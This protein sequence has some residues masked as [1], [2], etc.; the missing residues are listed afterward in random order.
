MFHEAIRKILIAGRPIRPWTGLFVLALLLPSAR[1][2]AQSGD[3]DILSSAVPPNVMILFDNSGSMNH[4]LWD[5]DFDPEVRY[6]AFCSFGLAPMISNSSCPGHGNPS[7]ECPDNEVRGL[8]ISG[9]S[10]QNE[11]RCS[12]TRTLYHD[13][14]TPQTTWYSRN[15]L[16]WLYGVSTTA[17]R[18]NEPQQSRL[19]V[20]KSATTTVVTSLTSGATELIRFGLMEFK[21]TNLSYS[22]DPDGGQVIVPIGVG[23]S[24]FV[25]AAISATEGD[26]WTPMGE[27]LVDVGRYFAGSNPLGTLPTSPMPSPI[28][29]SCRKNFALIVTD[30]EPTQDT[31]GHYSGAFETTI[32]NWDSDANEC[33]ALAP[34]TCIDAPGT[35]RDDGL[36]YKTS[37]K[38]T[39][40]L[41]DVAGYLYDT[42]LDPTLTGTQNLVTYTI[43]FLLDLPLLQ[44]AATN[45]GGSYYV[46]EPDDLTSLSTNLS[47]ALQSI[48]DRLG[49]FSSASVPTSRTAFGDSVY[50]AYFV[51]SQGASFW[52]GHLE[53]YELAANGDL[54]DAD[55]QVAV[56]PVTG[57]FIDPR[58]PI[59]DA[60]VELKSNSARSLYTTK[61]GARVSFDTATIDRI[62][63]GVTSADFGA[64]SGYSLVGFDPNDPNDV[65][66]AI[67][68]AL[69]GYVHG[70]D[71]FDED[72]D[73][74]QA[75]LRPNVLGDIFHSTPVIVGPPSLLLSAEDGYGV[76]APSAPAEPTF[77]ERFGQRDRVVYVGA[78]DGLLHAFDAGVYDGSDPNRL[79]TDGTGAEL[80]GY[81]PGLQLGQLK[82]LTRNDPRQYYYVDASPTA[83]SAW[84]GDGS[85]TDTTKEPGE[86][87]TVLVQ[88]FRQ[89]GAGYLALDVT[90]PNETTAEHSP[91][92]KFLWEFTDPDLGNS[93]SEPVI[94]RVKVAGVSGSGDQCGADD[95][96][97]DCREQWVA[98]FA[99]GYSEDG[100]PALVS[101][102]ADPANP[103][104][105]DR[106]KA[107]FIVALDSGSVLARVAFDAAGLT[108]PSEMRFSIPSSPA[109][110]DLNF[111]GFADVLYVGDLGGQV[112]KWDFSSVGQDTDFDGEIDSWSSG[113]F[114]R[115]DPTLIG[116]TYLHH[117]SIFYPPS[118]AFSGGELLLT[119]G[120]G[121][122]T[123]LGY[124]GSPSD[125]DNN[126]FFV[127]KDE[128]P[129]GSQAFDE[130]L[131]ED[132][133]TDITGS[134]T[135]TDTTDEGYFFT[136]EDS[137]KFI[138]QQTIFAGYVITASY[139]PDPNATGTCDPSGESRLYVFNLSTGL[140][141]FPQSG[142]T[143]DEDRWVSIGPGAPTS[144][145]IHLSPD[146][147]EIYI[148]TTL[149]NLVRLQA[150]PQS[151]PPVWPIYW[152]QKF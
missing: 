38:G 11:T 114:F 50:S 48:I 1:A 145:V 56:D 97:G 125:D 121:E 33:S 127:V 116:G 119:F 135:D 8:N 111:D 28:D 100:D 77:L 123:V 49:S 53:A 36:V 6:P 46:T 87:A 30:G 22:I 90:D 134:A 82:H 7:D 34:A 92:P 142:S 32:G 31:M 40:W 81:A 42:D 70:F 68:D 152:M 132:D 146:G 141:F 140:G 14:S 101:Y 15:Y 74:N 138:T 129:T 84:L 104:W 122:R 147:D 54:L 136:V 89:G 151:L 150:P 18:A 120:S 117:R 43:G 93:W 24:L 37:W 4:H 61:A 55:G 128:H 44:E 76:T 3:L 106:S 5:D 60:A 80:F 10:Q 17:E 52:P 58:N 20:A 85:G 66:E 144:P 71:G 139:V 99:G 16:N 109:V 83:A 75:E 35:G 2:A 26:T 78:N 108:G 51:P 112:W 79:Y 62:D 65:A 64:Y 21:P 73:A 29:L 12:V 57:A 72:G 133:L 95:G 63:L 148:Q 149:A 137:E 45:G 67:S 143:P 59:W 124:A 96:E 110:L 130:T 39:D 13:T 88:G 118:A 91:Y 27:A 126:R 19:Q 103:S 107:I 115:T 9:S 113:V 25:N 105:N 94:T 69:V 41:D 47:A 131:E 102:I 86:W 23:S 98:I